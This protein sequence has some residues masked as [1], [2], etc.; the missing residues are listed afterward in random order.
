M[1]KI[2]VG[3]GVAVITLVVVCLGVVTMAV[4]ADLLER[5][6]RLMVVGAVKITVGADVVVITLV[7]VCLG[8]VVVDLNQKM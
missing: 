7:V 8:V 5:G 3:A 2:T 6:S 1:V 4:V